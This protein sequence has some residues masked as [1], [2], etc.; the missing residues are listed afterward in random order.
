[1]PYPKSVLD[2]SNDDAAPHG[3]S[4]ATYVQKISNKVCLIRDRAIVQTI[5]RMLASYSRVLVV[6]G[7]S[8]LITQEPALESLL[9]KGSYFQL[10]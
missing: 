3:G 1:M 6:Y 5:E 4:N 9:G 8:H 7:G 10:D 2:I